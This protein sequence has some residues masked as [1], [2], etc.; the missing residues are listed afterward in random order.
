MLSAKQI[1]ASNDTVIEKVMTPEWGD[2]SVDPTER[3]V[4]VRGLRG[5]ERDDFEL[6]FPE[7]PKEGEAR[8][9]A[10]LRAL[11]WR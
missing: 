1:L 2:D 11:L 3:F 6:A 4:F 7:K 10:N 5:N 8:A 9:K